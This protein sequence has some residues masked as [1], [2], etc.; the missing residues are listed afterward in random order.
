MDGDA[1]LRRHRPSQRAPNPVQLGSDPR[2]AF[3]STLAHGFAQPLRT[4]T[5]QQ[6]EETC[7]SFRV[8]SLTRLTP[9]I[10]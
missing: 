6:Q 5:R 7:T 8:E 9:N 2:D 3:D 1:S 10:A 4:A